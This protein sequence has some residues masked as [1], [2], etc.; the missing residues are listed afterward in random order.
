V[1]DLLDLT[2]LESGSLK[3]RKEWYPLEE[4]VSSALGRLEPRLEG[5][6]VGVDLPREVL[7][8][9]MDPI[10]VEQVFINLIENAVKYSPAGSPIEIS[11]Q[12]GPD[13]VV[14]AIADRGPGLPPGEEARVF[15]RFYRVADGRRAEGAGLGLAVCQ[16]I[17]KIHGGRVEAGNRPGGGAVF[18]FALPLEGSPP[19][20]DETGDGQ[21][22]EEE[23]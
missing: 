3:A 2:R 17:L 5:R 15:E 19:P 7:L 21:L 6:K 4:V 11:A 18:R 23:R 1:G 10:L 16:A 22:P 14:V 9:P 8:A 13:E 12:A 20:P